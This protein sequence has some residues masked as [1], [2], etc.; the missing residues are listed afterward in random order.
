MFLTAVTSLSQTFR[1][2][3][4]DGTIKIHTIY[5]R[6]HIEKHRKIEAHAQ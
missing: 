6:Y 3:Q 5:Q 2:R 1:G 4:K